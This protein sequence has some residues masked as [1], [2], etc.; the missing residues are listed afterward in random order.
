MEILEVKK[1]IFIFLILFSFFVSIPTSVESAERN[2]VLSWT[3]NTEIDMSLYRVYKSDK[4]GQYDISKIISTADKGITKIYITL[5]F[6]GKSYFFIVTAIDQTG[7]ESE[8]S[9]EVSTRTAIWNWLQDLFTWNDIKL[10]MEK[11]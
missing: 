5:P 3:A 9:N 10:S 7:N 1:N 8:R 6:D 2:Y 4:K 11:G